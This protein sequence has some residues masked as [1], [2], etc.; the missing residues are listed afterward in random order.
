MPS[1]IDA[2]TEDLLIIVRAMRTSIDDF[3]RQY[4]LPSGLVFMLP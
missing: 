4:G 2:V 3:I 1:E